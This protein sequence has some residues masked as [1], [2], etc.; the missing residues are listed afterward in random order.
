MKRNP[1]TFPSSKRSV[2]NETEFPTLC[3]IKYLRTNV[4]P[5]VKWHCN[6]TMHAEN[7]II[8][9]A[10]CCPG[11]RRVLSLQASKPLFSSW[12]IHNITLRSCDGR[13]REGSREQWLTPQRVH[14]RG[15]LPS[16]WSCCLLA[17]FF[18]FN[19]ALPSER[20][21]IYYNVTHIINIWLLLL[22]PKY[23]VAVVN[24]SF[25][26][27]LNTPP[28]RPTLWLLSADTK[29]SEGANTWLPWN[30]LTCLL[31]SK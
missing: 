20:R 15:F 5:T 25:S 31:W 3:C 24:L 9:P 27:L 12:K 14:S 18:S 23:C 10:T 8:L 4:L 16:C 26:T 1:L 22:S 13:F 17:S 30:L 11:S 7:K 2:L 19:Q 28:P 21:P 6:S 29:D